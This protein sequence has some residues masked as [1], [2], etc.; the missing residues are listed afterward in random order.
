[1]EF[2]LPGELPFL[3][4]HAHLAVR[5][6]ERDALSHAA[7]DFLDT[8]GELVARV[9]H[10]VLGH[11]HILYGE[12]GYIQTVVHL[13]EHRNEHFLDQLHV[14][15]IARREVRAYQADGAGDAVDAVAV[16]TDEFEHIRILL[17]RHDAGACGEG[18]REFHEGEILAVE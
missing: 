6:T 14:P 4:L 13:L 3:Y 7:V 1:M 18:V 11:S 12:L 16:R 17:V 8:E 10:Q 5:V 15:E 9:G 2:S